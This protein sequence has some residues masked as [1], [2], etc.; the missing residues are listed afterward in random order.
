MKRFNS[1]FL[2]TLLTSFLL[3]APPLVKSDFDTNEAY[4]TSSGQYTLFDYIPIF[5]SDYSE[6]NGS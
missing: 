4:I 5:D 3:V 2:C 1:C 6:G